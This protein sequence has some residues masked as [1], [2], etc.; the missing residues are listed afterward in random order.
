[1]ALRCVG[2]ANVNPDIERS[3]TQ[4]IDDYF[5]HRFR[6]D[7]RLVD[8][9]KILLAIRLDDSRLPLCRPQ[10]R[11]QVDQLH[12]SVCN[13]P[14]VIVEIDAVALLPIDIALSDRLPRPVIS[15]RAVLDTD[16][17]ANRCRYVLAS[18]GDLGEQC[19]LHS[20]PRPLDRRPRVI[21]VR[22]EKIHRVLVDVHFLQVFDVAGGLFRRHPVEILGRLRGSLDNG[23]CR[24]VV[25]ALCVF[26][27]ADFAPNDLA[28][29]DHRPDAILRDERDVLASPQLRPFQNLHAIQNEPLHLVRVNLAHHGPTVWK[30]GEVVRL[31]VPVVL[32]NHAP[33]D[34]LN[35]GP[36]DRSLAPICCDPDHVIATVEPSATRVRQDFVR[37]LRPLSVRVLNLELVNVH[38]PDEESVHRVLFR[39]LFRRAKKQ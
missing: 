20:R 32:V 19:L 29:V 8:G 38:V 10:F 17:S 16:T 37:P 30:P 33:I 5:T 27:F 11:Y 34:Q 28:T 36:L 31:R 15:R 18:L 13:G 35:D 26:A 14:D 3:L 22:C 7:N 6:V 21:G 2:R 39:R 25:D 23:R 12:A 24:I 1:M 9:N 4:V